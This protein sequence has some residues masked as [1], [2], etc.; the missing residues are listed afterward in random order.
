MLR[1]DGHVDAR[2]EYVI[3]LRA[4]HGQPFL[5]L[6]HLLN[7]VTPQASARECGQCGVSAPFDDVRFTSVAISGAPALIVLDL[8]DDPPRALRYDLQPSVN[9]RLV[10]RGELVAEY[11]LVAVI[12]Y[13]KN[14]HFITDAL[15]PQE[16]RWLRYDGNWLG[17]LAQPVAPTPGR[18][19]HRCKEYIP[20]MVA[21][22]RVSDA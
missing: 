16:L 7:T 8:P 15:D 12:L 10:L 21:Y 9:Q 13:A 20:V 18:V 3:N 11:R 14:Y 5:A 6:L 17:G 4:G 2:W 1:V 22:A 19:Q